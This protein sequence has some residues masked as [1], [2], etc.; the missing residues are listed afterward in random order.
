MSHAVRRHTREHAAALAG[1]GVVSLTVL[2]LASASTLPV[3]GV[4][5]FA[6]MLL[7]S[8]VFLCVSQHQAV[9]TRLQPLTR[10]RACLQGLAMAAP[11]H[12][13][14]NFRAHEGAA[15]AGQAANLGV[16]VSQVVQSPCRCLMQ[17]T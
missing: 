2:P 5:S 16:Q 7:A 11:R 17:G 9:S 13:L 3:R 4:V 12:Q 15:N 10:H 6:V 1:L 14:P 8:A